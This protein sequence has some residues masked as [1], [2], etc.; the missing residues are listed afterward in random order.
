MLN[1]V[2]CDPNV[3][4]VNLF[5]L[6]DETSLEGWQ[7][8]LYYAGYVPK[9]SAAAVTNWIAQTSGN[10]TGATKSWTPGT[11]P[12]TANPVTKPKTKVTTKAKP[13]AK[14]KPVT[15]KKK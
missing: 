6:V 10:C 2:A 8:G 1:Y 11:A 9:A 5:H 7:S 14:A 15:H 12:T 4:V 13:K 3:K